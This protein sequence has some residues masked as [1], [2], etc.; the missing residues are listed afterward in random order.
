MHY[1][2]YSKQEMF[3]I[4]LAPRLQCSPDTPHNLPRGHMWSG[5]SH[6][7][8]HNPFSVPPQ[9][10]A[11]LQEQY[12]QPLVKKEEMEEKMRN[13]KEV[14]CRVVTCK[15]VSEVEPGRQQGTGAQIVQNGAGPSCSLLSVT[16][17][18]IVQC[19]D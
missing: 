8:P 11:E 5:F 10:E 9:A 1:V 14:K 13:I 15:T 2:D 18:A 16:H 4:S 12:F 17:L 7:S 6:L 19:R 3:V